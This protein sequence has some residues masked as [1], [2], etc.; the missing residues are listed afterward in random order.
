MNPLKQARTRQGISQRSLAKLSNVSF[1]SVQQMEGGKHDMRL[2]SLSKVAQAMHYPPGSITKA[3]ERIFTQPPL[4]LKN[5]AEQIVHHGPNSW[6]I[7]LFDFVDAFRRE[8][9]ESYVLEAP[10]SKLPENLRALLAATTE[11]LC[12]ELNLP[13]PWWTPAMPKLKEPWFV[14]GTENLKAM[15]L[16][17]APVHFRKRNIFVLYNFL[18]RA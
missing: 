3:I 8:R 10:S 2:S 9:D 16:V 5:V 15:A 17:E 13:Q 18:E 7:W 4:A 12:D 6:K 14:S 1:R 11:T